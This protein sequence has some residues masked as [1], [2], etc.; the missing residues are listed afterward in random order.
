MSLVYPCWKLQQ[1][2]ECQLHFHSSIKHPAACTVCWFALA[3]I[4]NTCSMKRGQALKGSENSSWKLSMKTFKWKSGKVI[5]TIRGSQGTSYHCKWILH[6]L[7]GLIDHNS[8]VT[9]SHCS[10]SKCSCSV[11]TGNRIYDDKVIMANTYLEVKSMIAHTYGKR[12]MW[13]SHAP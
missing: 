11:Q 9:C 10:S 2:S 7:K 3:Y 6:P 13:E 1:T 5:Q 8:I 12:L 4:T